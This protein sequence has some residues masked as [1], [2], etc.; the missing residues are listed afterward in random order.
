MHKVWGV[1][2]TNIL[3]FIMIALAITL[4]LVIP[5]DNEQRMPSCEKFQGTCSTDCSLLNISYQEFAHYRGADAGCLE[6]E[7]CCLP[8]GSDYNKRYND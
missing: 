1:K 5:R 7:Y 8:I 2:W 3:S 6:N 4:A